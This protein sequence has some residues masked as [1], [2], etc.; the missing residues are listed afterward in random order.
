VIAVEAK[1]KKATGELKAIVLARGSHLMDL[2]IIDSCSQTL[3]SMSHKSHAR[4]REGTAGRLKNPAR[5]TYPRTSTLR[6][7]HSRARTTDATPSL[8]D[9][10][11]PPRDEPG[12][13]RLTTEGSR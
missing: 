8:D 7:S 3:T 13:D 12:S 9:P 11:Y 10:E 5:S 2:V 1:I 6:I 4:A